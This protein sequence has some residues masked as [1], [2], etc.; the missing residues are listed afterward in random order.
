MKL[1]ADFGR[2]IDFAIELAEK[3]NLYDRKAELALVWGPL[4]REWLHEVIPD[5][6]EQDSVA[7]LHV[8]V[9]PAL[10]IKHPKLVSDFQSK[11]DVINAVMASIHVPVFLDG[12]PWTKYRGEIVLDGS[13]WWFITRNFNHKTCPLPQHV[14]P[15]DMFIVDWR[16]DMPH[17]QKLKKEILGGPAFR[18]LKPNFVYEMVEAG[19]LFMKQQHNEGKLPWENSS[20]RF[21]I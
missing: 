1:N 19:Y 18:V 4:I 11:E 21:I 8:T 20:K 14:N 13:F 3:S 5:T 17:R 15:E 6:L 16:K 12:K 10:P 2:S 7:G 9:T